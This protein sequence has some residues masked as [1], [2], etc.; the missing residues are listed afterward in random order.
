MYKQHITTTNL[1]NK[2]LTKW[3]N[4]LSN[5]DITIKEYLVAQA[6]PTMGEF[7]GMKLVNKPLDLDKESSEALLE[8]MLSHIKLI[9]MQARDSHI[10]D[11]FDNN[12]PNSIDANSQPTNANAIVRVTFSEFSFYPFFKRGALTINEFHLLCNK[13]LAATDE[14]PKNLHICLSSIP[15]IDQNNKVFNITIY[16]QCGSHSQINVF[17][18]ACPSDVDP[19]YPE[20]TNPYYAKIDADNQL[21]TKFKKDVLALEELILNGDLQTI[22]ITVENILAKMKARPSYLLNNEGNF[23]QEICRIEELCK[24][25]LTHTTDEETFKKIDRQSIAIELINTIIEYIEEYEFARNDDSQQLLKLINEVSVPQAT[26]GTH[27]NGGVTLYIGGLVECTTAGGAKFVTGIDVCLD[28]S[29]NF[30]ARLYERYMENCLRDGK[31]ITPYFSHIITSNSITVSPD[32]QP[33]SLVV[34]CDVR[35][36]S[37]TDKHADPSTLLPENS[38]TI[39]DSAFGSQALIECYKPYLLKKIEGNYRSRI[40]YYNKMIRDR[41]SASMLHQHSSDMGTNDILNAY[42]KRSSLHTMQP[43]SFRRFIL[44]LILPDLSYHDSSITDHDV[45]SALEKHNDIN[46]DIMG[47]SLLHWA[48]IHG[49]TDI[50]EFA[51]KNKNINLHLKNEHGYTAFDLA[52]MYN[53]TEIAS[54]LYQSLLVKGERTTSV[55]AADNAQPETKAKLLTTAMAAGQ[56]LDVKYFLEIGADYFYKNYHTTHANAK[57]SK[58]TPAIFELLYERAN[59]TDQLLYLTDE[60]ISNGGPKSAT[61]LLELCCRDKLEENVSYL[62]RHHRYFTPTISEI[63]KLLSLIDKNDGTNIYTTVKMHLV[64]LGYG[65]YLNEVERKSAPVHVNSYRPWSPTGQN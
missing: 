38:T 11:N 63:D 17:A 46:A 26:L 4:A 60:T 44:E 43:A 42:D 20:S 39:N 29:Y 33:G 61:L 31:I 51:L 9:C 34:H 24:I 13:L 47:N 65:N 16:L 52:I 64:K 48:I 35:N 54:T 19:Q 40:A 49:L 53:R 56:V 32:E 30:A 12:S 5:N 14:Y 18:K 59:S 6:E 8:R 1:I 58:L 36:S 62:L 3:H 7:N 15:L 57:I 27:D 2:Q 25:I 28:N 41:A 21:A 45:K 37:I 22:K 10:K 50:V 55:D 23:Y